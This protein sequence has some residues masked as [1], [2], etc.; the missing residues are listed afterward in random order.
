MITAI[1]KEDNG[2]DMILL[3]ITDKNIE[4]LRQDRPIHMTNKSHPAVPEGM[5]VVILWGKDEKDIIDKLSKSG[6]LDGAE[7][8][9]M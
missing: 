9:R 1:G 5:T 4:R 6:A 2:N 7:I 3:G 8:R